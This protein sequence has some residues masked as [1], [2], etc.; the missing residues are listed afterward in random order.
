M[1]RSF[2]ENNNRIQLCQFDNIIHVQN[3]GMFKGN[4]AFL[5]WGKTLQRESQKDVLKFKTNE[6]KVSKKWTAYVGK[7]A[8][9]SI[10]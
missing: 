5:D 3:Y 1:N 7:R 2:C 6:N 10:E 9:C 4:S 8:F